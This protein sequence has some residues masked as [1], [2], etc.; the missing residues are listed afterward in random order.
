M[1]YGYRFNLGNN[2]VYELFGYV[3][4]FSFIFVSNCTTNTTL[5]T[6][7]AAAIPVLESLLKI[8]YRQNIR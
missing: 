4:L 5:Q 2:A 1:T 8:A 7:T 6:I 3:I